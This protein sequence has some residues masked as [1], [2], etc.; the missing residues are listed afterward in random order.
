MFLDHRYDM[1]I[2]L[3]ERKRLLVNM[4]K[5]K[6]LVIVGSG[7]FA[8][9]AYE[10]FT[11]DS[12]YCVTAFAVERK[13]RDKEELFGLPVVDFEDIEVK[14]S[15]REYETYV[16]VTY[17]QLNRVRKR[18]YEICKDKGYTCAS[19]VS[20]KAFLWHN[21][22]VG[23]NTFIFED[24]TVQ[25]NADIGN[26]VVLWSGNHIGHRTVI[27]D[28][29]WLTSHAVISGFCHIGK[30]CFIGVNATLGDCVEIAEDILLGAGALT[31]KNLTQKGQV[32]IGNPAKMMGRTSYEQFNINEREE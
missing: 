4:E 23:E 20:S 14:Y 16:A 6:K 28:N 18:L 7:E 29:C 25:Y 13:Y 26:N 31:I 24:N 3:N 1:E 21:V 17:T 12:D 19:Y 9:I 2:E 5:T 27:E 15:P 32:Y 11:Y 22:K 30:N 8:E 10:Y